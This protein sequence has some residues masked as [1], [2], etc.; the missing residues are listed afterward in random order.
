MLRGKYQSAT[1]CVYGSPYDE[2]GGGASD[3]ARRTPV[4]LEC[5][6]VC[7]W[8]AYSSMC[9][10]V[11]YALTAVLSA[12]AFVRW[13]VHRTRLPCR[14]IMVLGSALDRV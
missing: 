14:R 3:E 8:L 4:C 11:V 12:R 7:A 13:V 5:P 10:T 2:E 9:V 1:V 6:M